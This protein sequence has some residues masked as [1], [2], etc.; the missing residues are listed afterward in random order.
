[1]HLR[2]LLRRYKP[3]LVFIYE[4]YVAF[5]KTENFW[6]RVGYQAIAIEEAQGHSG[7]IW[8]LKNPQSS[9]KIIP[10]KSMH[11]SITVRVVQGNSGWL[12]SGV[13]ANPIYAARGNLWSYLGDL[14][15]NISEPW[16]A[17]GDFNEILHVTEKRGGY[18]SMARANAFARMLDQYDLIDMDFFGSKFTW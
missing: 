10:W 16:V 17:I 6:R 7:G 15:S 9:I 18:F 14:R 8:A 5:G 2:E 11:E 13:Y 12:C 3:E 4:T 1:M